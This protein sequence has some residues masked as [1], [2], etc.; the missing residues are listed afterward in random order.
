MGLVDRAFLLSH[1]EFHQKDFELI[2]I[3]WGNDY[4]L[5]FIFNT[6]SVRIKGLI[7]DKI[8]KQKINTTE[9]CSNKKIWFIVPF[10]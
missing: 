8:T 1:P 2:K 7:N 4:P 10:I 5:D 3:L 9:K 6:I